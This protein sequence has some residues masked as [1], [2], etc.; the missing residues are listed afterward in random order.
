MRGIKP[1]N[2]RCIIHTPRAGGMSHAT[3]NKTSRREGDLCLGRGPSAWLCRY[4]KGIHHLYMRRQRPKANA[5]R[6]RDAHPLAMGRYQQP[7]TP[8]SQRRDAQ[9]AGKR[10]KLARENA[11]LNHD[12]FGARSASDAARG[13]HSTGEHM[14]SSTG[15]ERTVYDMGI[16]HIYM[17]RQR[18]KAKTGQRR[19]AHPSKRRR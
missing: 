4:S 11:P 7:M 17:R 2:V 16:H 8:T 1:G 18:P 10:Q 5:G 9:L 15:A 6:R 12:G 3:V 13:G 14:V 19:D